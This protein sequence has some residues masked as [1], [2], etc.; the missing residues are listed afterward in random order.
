MFVSI[1]LSIYLWN[2]LCLG[3]WLCKESRDTTRERERV[4]SGDHH[5]RIISSSVS[6]THIP[7]SSSYCGTLLQLV[8]FI[9]QWLVE[10]RATCFWYYRTNLLHQDA[11]VSLLASR[12]KFLFEKNGCTTPNPQSS[13][14]WVP[15]C[16]IRHLRAAVIMSTLTGDARTLAATTDSP[17][18]KEFYHLVGSH[19]SSDGPLFFLFILFLD[20]ED[21]LT[22]CRPVLWTI[23]QARALALFLFIF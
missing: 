3:C 1:Y 11:V 17:R 20:R 15:P 12:L 18:G 23:D 10:S 5:A 2:I 14:F 7:Y 22:L 19:A 13:F 16:G 8:S 4:A 6:S 9:S 21:N